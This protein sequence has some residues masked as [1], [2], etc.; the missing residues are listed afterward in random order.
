MSLMFLTTL[1]IGLQACDDVLKS[2]E[3]SLASFQKDLGMVSTE[4]ET[5]Q[6]RS[7]ALNTRLENRKRVEKILAPA[8]EEVSIAPTTVTTISEGPIDD[9]WLKALAELQGKLQ[10]N[11]GRG[12]L[13]DDIK[14]GVDI[15][16]LLDNLKS[17]V[18]RDHPVGVLVSAKSRFAGRRTDT[19]LPCRP[20]QSHKISQHQRSNHTATEAAGLQRPVRLPFTNK[21]ETCR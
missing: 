14:A 7:T 9:A 2:V 5:L 21:F 15:K 16:P 4:I 11:E 12:E 18:R 19:R 3:T 1:I 17:R 13:P 10:V 20:D 6:S 8:V